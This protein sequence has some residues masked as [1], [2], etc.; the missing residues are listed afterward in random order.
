MSVILDDCRELQCNRCTARDFQERGFIQKN[1]FCRP[2]LSR[3]LG[4]ALV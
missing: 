2:Q 3:P 1:F 4:V